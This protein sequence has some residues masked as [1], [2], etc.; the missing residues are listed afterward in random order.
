MELRVR[1]VDEES[2]AVVGELALGGQKMALPGRLPTSS[3]LRAA[4][5]WKMLDSLESPALVVARLMT[6]DLVHSI[7]SQEEVW[8]RFSR[9]LTADI[10]TMPGAARI[11]YLSYRSVEMEDVDQIRTFLDL[12]HLMGFEPVTVQYGTSPSTE[13]FLAVFS[14]A[15][16]WA[17]ERGVEHL[18]PVVPPLAT[19]EEA[20][21]LLRSLLDR[22]ASALGVDLQGRFPYHTLRAVEELKAE[23]P[24]IWIHAFQVPPKVR[25]GRSLLHASQG[26]VLPFYGVDSF[27]R[28]VVPPPPEP[29][30]KER[31][32]FFDPKG[33]GVLKGPEYREVYGDSLTCRC[34]TCRGKGLEDFMSPDDR[35]FLNLAKVHDHFSQSEELRA[36]ADRLQEMGYR[37]ILSSR[38]FTRTFLE[39]VPG[40][41]R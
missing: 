26:M 23:N 37:S 18:M 7:A 25:L 4:R 9:G 1:L 33:W 16:S 8:Q 21:E 20:S 17:R 6:P 13:D 14:Y 28:W 34:R 3:E 35:G 2:S 39:R 22:G 27:S 38:S 41:E 32:N 40:G 29:V 11:L 10:R 19:R 31:V 15:R 12:Q 30:R 24:E 5:S 36:A